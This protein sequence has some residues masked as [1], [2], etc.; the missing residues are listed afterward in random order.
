MDAM[1]MGGCPRAGCAGGVVPGSV[2]EEHIRSHQPDPSRYICTHL[3]LL[4]QGGSINCVDSCVPL[5]E[6]AAHIMLLVVG[7][8]GLCERRPNPRLL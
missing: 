1:F 2:R 8:P 6:G 5:L 3:R 4:R 7:V